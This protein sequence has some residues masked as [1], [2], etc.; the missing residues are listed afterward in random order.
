MKKLLDRFLLIAF[1]ILSSTLLYAQAPPGNGNPTNPSGCLSPSRWGPFGSTG[2]GYDC[3]GCGQYPACPA[4][5][6][7]SCFRIYNIDPTHWAIDFYPETG[8]IE[9]IIVTSYNIIPIYNV[10]TGVLDGYHLYYVE[11][12]SGGAPKN[13]Q[14]GN[15]KP[16]IQK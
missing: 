15:T 4:S 10:D 11:T 13:N 2:K 9:T 8:G 6:C 14:P 5:P 12:G 3:F 7:L 16:N 1:S